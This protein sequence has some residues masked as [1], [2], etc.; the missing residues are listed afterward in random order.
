MRTVEDHFAG[1]DYGGVR[2]NI[3]LQVAHMVADA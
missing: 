1:C 3:R 2:M